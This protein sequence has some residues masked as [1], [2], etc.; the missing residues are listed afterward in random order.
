MNIGSPD[1]WPV[2][3]LAR[4]VIRLV[5][6][7]VG[8]RFVDRPADD[9]RVRQPDITLAGQELGWKPTTSVQD[10]LAATIAWFR[11]HPGLLG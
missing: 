6:R 9:P 4:L 1:E 2:E 7:Q 3:D 10:G 11:R 5:G 8:I